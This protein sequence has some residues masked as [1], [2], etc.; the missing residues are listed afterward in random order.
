MLQVVLFHCLQ[1]LYIILEF[2]Q[3][4]LEIHRLKGIR[5]AWQRLRDK[6]K[7]KPTPPKHLAVLFVQEDQ[8]LWTW[9]ADI[10][11]YASKYGI[12]R[13]T[14]YD[15]WSTLKTQEKQLRSFLC[16]IF[17]DKRERHMLLFDGDGL[18][19]PKGALRVT[20][21]GRSAGKEALVKMCKK[22]CLSGE[23]ITATR[24]SDA[25][26]EQHVDEPDFLVKVGDVSTLAGY[27]PWS[28]RVTEIHQLAKFASPERVQEAEF[29]ELL[30]VYAGRDRRLGR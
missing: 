9:I 11:A 1:F 4:L 15:P 14:I 22:F 30:H 21:L 18:D 29:E 3:S 20:V 23:P 10:V 25:L 13:V 17:G 26:A 16:R 24:I 12:E 8:I 5:G 2:V 7:V 19:A 6:R 27:P 28:L